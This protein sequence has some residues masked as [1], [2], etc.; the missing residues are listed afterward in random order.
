MGYGGLSEQIDTYIYDNLKNYMGERVIN[1]TTNY[2]GHMQ[3]IGDIIT[4]VPPQPQKQ[5]ETVLDKSIQIPFYEM[6][7][8]FLYAD[9]MKTE[10]AHFYG[11]Q[12]LQD[13]SRLHKGKWKAFAGHVKICHFVT[14]L[15]TILEE[16]RK[17]ETMDIVQ[18]WKAK[19][20]KCR[21]GNYADRHIWYK[22]HYSSFGNFVAD[23]YESERLL[24]TWEIVPEP[25]EHTKIY[26]ALHGG[27]MQ[28]YDSK[29]YIDQSE[30]IPDGSE[31]TVKWKE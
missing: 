23:V 2:F 29:G 26:L 19:G 21:S 22:S 31:I 8:H 16:E 6:T 1:V 30:H 20:N 9:S 28:V 13:L 25:K 17:V 12:F 24:E 10:M 18:V 27:H 4:F 5:F 7:K 15:Y 14:L 3:N 11:R